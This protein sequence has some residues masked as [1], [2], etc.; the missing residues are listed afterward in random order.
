MKHTEIK[1]NSQV[2]HVLSMKNVE[3]RKRLV[4]NKKKDQKA[5]KLLWKIKQDSLKFRQVSK[6]LM[7]Q[8]PNFIYR[9]KALISLKNTKAPSLSAQNKKIKDLSLINAFHNL[10]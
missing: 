7:H 9:F 2:V 6:D 4:E 8:T 1:Y 3:D 5:K 10:F